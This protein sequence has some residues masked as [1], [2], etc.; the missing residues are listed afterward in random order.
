[1]NKKIFAG[2][3]AVT[4]CAA[5]AIPFAA[6]TPGSSSDHQ[7][8][9]LAVKEETVKDYNDM[10]VFKDIAAE[11]GKDVYWT[12]RTSAQYNSNTDKV[13]IKGV[14]AIYHSGFTNLQLNDYGKRGRIV[15]INE[16]LDHMPNLK[17]ILDSRPDIEQA[18]LAPDGNIYSLPRVEEMGL[19]TYPNIL[20][21]NKKWVEK[22]IDQG[23]MPAGVSVTKADLVDGLDISRS[24]FKKILEAFQDHDM[25]SS[26]ADK[27]EVPLS[28]V[29][30][31]WQGNESDLISSFGLPENRQHK[32]L[33][34]GKITFTV[35]DDKWFDAI[36]ELNDWYRKGLIRTSS[37]DQ[38]QDT[39]LAKGQ[40]G[41]YGSFYWW[42]KETVVA[43][44]LR[45][46]YIVVKPLKN[47]DG[48][49]YVGPSNELE[50]EKAECVVL[51]TC[52]DKAGLL[53]YFDKFYEPDYSAQLNYGSISAGAFKAEKENGKLVPN[54]DHGNQSADDFRMQNA[55][56]GIVYLTEEVFRNNVVM[57]SRA[58]LRQ[59]RLAQYVTPYKYEGA[60]P[61]P[62]LNYTEAEL[63]VLSKY[64]S[65]LG[66]NINTYMT[67]AITGSTEPKKSDWEK[68]VSDNKTSI[69]NI[70]K[71][72]Q[73]AYDR[74][75]AAIKK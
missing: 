17:K 26:I 24:D 34:N 61:I 33:L 43:K 68:M 60:Q 22:L 64:E 75:V 63:K 52:K 25:D 69:D 56:Y 27:D 32:T 29:S 5:T 62:N 74:Y 39:F 66:K 1:M 73:D 38:D 67:N 16:Y 12:F 70:K 41:R 30:D 7:F 9:V 48:K 49:R 3:M 36:K 45:D 54:E 14:D 57:E 4:M 51:G 10:Q 18:L 6:C 40:D 50:V 44:D 19:K 42:E 8:T 59:Q 15:A 71:T 58:Q 2:I 37:Y 46:D 72:N 55:P 21:L 11:T 28:F 20:F 65:T 23:W 53:S 35:E 47:D 13:G 31:N